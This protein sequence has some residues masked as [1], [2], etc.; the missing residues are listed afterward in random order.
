VKRITALAATLALTAGPVL[1]QE[2]PAAFPP[3]GPQM[4]VPVPLPP[5]PVA[6]ACRPGV[7]RGLYSYPY[8]DALAVRTGPGVEYPTILVL[9]EGST[10]VVCGTVGEWGFLRS[11]AVPSLPP[12]DLP[13]GVFLVPCGGA[14]ASLRFIVPIP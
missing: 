6:P 3:P 1:G 10:V 2:L 9:P 8:A 4:A 5:P 14:F 13:P 11:C 12:A 7:V